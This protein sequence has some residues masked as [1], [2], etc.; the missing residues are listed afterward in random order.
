MEQGQKGGGDCDGQEE[1][2]TH[3]QGGIQ[4]QRQGD[5]RGQVGDGQLG[6]VGE[7]AAHT[8]FKLGEDG[9]EVAQQAQ[10][11]QKKHI[12]GHK[13]DVAGAVERCSL[14]EQ[15]IEN[16][17]NRTDSH[18]HEGGQGANLEIF[19]EGTKKQ[20]PAL[21]LAAADT[22]RHCA[23]EGGGGGP[24][25]E[26]GQRADQPEHTEEKEI[27]QLFDQ[28]PEVVFRIKNACGHEGASF[29]SQARRQFAGPVGSEQC[30]NPLGQRGG[31]PGVALPC[32]V[33]EVNGVVRQAKGIG[34]QKVAA[35]FRGDRPELAGQAQGFFHAAQSHLL[36][37]GRSLHSLSDGGRGD[38]QKV[39]LPARP[40]VDGLCLPHQAAQALA[41]GAGV[42][43]QPLLGIVG[44]QHDHQ[45]GHRRVA[46]EAWIEVGQGAQTLLHRVVKDGG[47]S[48]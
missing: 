28:T 25:G 35:G 10:R 30:G 6:A 20:A 22:A 40:A 26:H 42:G 46:H 39:G 44:A 41:D 17:Q 43:A 47:A 23:V 3:R 38:N 5:R 37:H 4:Q 9:E 12:V 19:P 34:V 1:V 31:Q 32:E 13:Q 2:E 16:E 15:G 36:G 24:Q 7:E 29:L 33:H 14:I 18:H 11:Q 45:Q 27:H 48:G 21:A 8:E